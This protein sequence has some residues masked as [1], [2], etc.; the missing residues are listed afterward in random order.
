M[1]FNSLVELIF[2]KDF[3][4]KILA[5]GMPQDVADYLHGMSDKY[6]FWFADQI[7]KMPEY[8]AARNKEMFVHSLQTQMQGIIDWIR[9]G[10]QNLV[11]KDYDWNTALAFADEYHKKL[12]ITNI[13]RETNTILKEYADGFYWVDLES[14]SDS[15]EAGAMGH[16]ANTSK[17][18]TLYSLR[19]YNIIKDAIESFITIAVSPDKG[20]WFQCKG[21]N[22]SKPKKEYYS[23][24]AD[25]LVSKNILTFKTEYDSKNDFKTEDLIK[26]LE[27]NP[28]VFPNTDEILEKINEN[29]ISIDDFQKVLDRYKEDFK[30]YSI[31]LYNDFDE[32]NSIYPNYNFYLKIQKSETNLPIDCLT[33]D[34]R[35]KGRQALNDSLD[36]YLSDVSVDNYEDETTII[37]SIEDSDNSFSLDEIGLRSFKQQ[38]E[39]YKGLNEK[40][41]KEEFLKEDLEKILYLD[42]CI[43]I[44]R[45][46]FEEDVK[47]ELGD[48]YET[49]FN[50]R[51]LELIV[52]IKTPN[53]LF[54][55]PHIEKLSYNS[56]LGRYDYTVPTEKDF[57]ENYKNGAKTTYADFYAIVLFWQSV[58]RDI[59]VDF[60]KH[61]IIKISK[62]YD[63]LNFPIS[64]EYSYKDDD[65]IDYEYEFRCLQILE[66]KSQEIQRSLLSFYN[67]VFV[68]ILKSIEDFNINPDNLTFDPLGNS[69]IQIYTK[70][71]RYY[72]GTLPEEKLTTTDV[73]KLA[74]SKGLTGDYKALDVSLLKQWLNDNMGSTPILSGFKDFFESRKI[75]EFQ[76]DFI[77]ETINSN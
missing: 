59:L 66:N 32:S 17:G 8:Q 29:T 68:K 64:F 4:N 77:N 30:F 24:I 39:Y 14:S 25:I 72:L 19:K 13:E 51:T 63:V 7:N 61:M 48:F 27:E 52:H 16:C 60:S 11:L 67:S 36:V 22:N 71:P 75:K 37:G 44:N 15:C 62:T 69:S 58:K 10:V 23:Y 20:V 56:V 57:L 41:D 18:D 5:I 45:D 65:E 54:Q 21:R 35:S 3:R 46:S 55:T 73:K 6:S 40:F 70:N 76:K 28:N 26:Y 34:Y 12:T 42:D 49:R 38:C 50:Q 9:G 2:E 1:N 53:D 47:K 33:L 43:E 74:D 31:D